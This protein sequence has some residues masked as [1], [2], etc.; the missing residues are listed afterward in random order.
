MNILAALL[1]RVGF[2]GLALGTIALVAVGLIVSQ[3]VR[4]D[5]AHDRLK[6]AEAQ[7]SECNTGA[8]SLEQHI[9][10]QNE[11]VAALE[12]AGAAQVK[13]AQEAATAAQAA[14]TAAEARVR[15]L[16]AQ[17]VPQDCAQAVQWGAS[18][19][20]GLAERWTP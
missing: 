14:R 17:P 8:A 2:Q 19:G 13:R 16:M 20:A 12:A 10:Q 4:L 5:R 18:V 15:A 3:G 1:S 11:A 6:V 7:L 9:R